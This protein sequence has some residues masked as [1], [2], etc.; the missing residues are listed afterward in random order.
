M[1]MD[2]EIVSNEGFE[3]IKKSNADYNLLKAFI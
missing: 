2:G 3:L 1:S